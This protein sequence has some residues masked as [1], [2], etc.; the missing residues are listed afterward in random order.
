MV[1]IRSREKLAIRH[2]LGSQSLGTHPRVGFS[3]CGSFRRLFFAS[4][5][6]ETF[7]LAVVI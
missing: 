1:V 4:S 2:N 6:F 3:S 5:L 7:L